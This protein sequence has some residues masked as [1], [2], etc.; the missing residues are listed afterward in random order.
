MGKRGLEGYLRHG[1]EDTLKTGTYPT[2]YG[3]YE[4]EVLIENGELLDGELP[5]RAKSLVSE[6]ARLNS[7]EL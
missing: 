2:I 1:V 5:T 7:W 3:H 4:A 6:W